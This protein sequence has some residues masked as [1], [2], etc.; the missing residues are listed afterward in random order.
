[1]QNQK[2]QRDFDIKSFIRDIAKRVIFYT[3]IYR[4]F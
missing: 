4:R 2:N 1:M 3:A